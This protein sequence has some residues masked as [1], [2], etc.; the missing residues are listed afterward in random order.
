MNDPK[1]LLHYHVT[2][3]LQMMMTFL[4]ALNCNICTREAQSRDQ[5]QFL[6]T[7]RHR[8]LKIKGEIRLFIMNYVAL[9]FA[10]FQEA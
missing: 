7:I 8:I 10:I 5:F 6:A 3:V 2:Q 1:R 9:L 4:R